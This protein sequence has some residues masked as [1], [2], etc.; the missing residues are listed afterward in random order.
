M[1]ELARA[2]RRFGGRAIREPGAPAP[3]LLDWLE[4][5]HLVLL[6]QYGEEVSPDD[7]SSLPADARAKALRD[8]SRVTLGSAKAAVLFLDC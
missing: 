2:S 4:K 3:E 8:F 7:W 1:T 5:G 6:D